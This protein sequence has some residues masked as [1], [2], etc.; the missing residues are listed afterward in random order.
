MQDHP[1]DALLSHVSELIGELE[2]AGVH[3]RPPEAEDTGAEA[4]AEDEWISDTS[5]VEMKE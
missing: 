4:E 3:P 5:D 2:K 1:D